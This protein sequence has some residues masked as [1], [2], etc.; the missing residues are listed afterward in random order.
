MPFNIPFPDSIELF[1]RALLKKVAESHKTV[2][3]LANT[4]PLIKQ[5]F[6]HSM[7]SFFDHFIAKYKLGNQTS[8]LINSMRTGE[9]RMTLIAANKVQEMNHF[10]QFILYSQ[11]T[12]YHWWKEVR[13][14]ER[15]EI[16]VVAG[17]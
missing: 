9:L 13:R 6:Q 15:L 11:V 4:I 14:I 17:Q 7:D 16:G 5:H 3:Q 10:S 1:M 2:I 12:I 8:D